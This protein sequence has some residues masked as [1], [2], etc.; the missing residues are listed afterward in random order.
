MITNLSEHQIDNS[1]TLII[2][3]VDPIG[4]KAVQ[5]WDLTVYPNPVHQT[6]YLESVLNLEKV[7]LIGIEG[8]VIQEVQ[9]NKLQ[10]SLDVSTLPQGIY[11]LEIYSPKGKVVKRIVKLK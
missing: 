11:F 8:R 7:R 5:G 2:T 4:S 1:T 9:P 6:I 3:S 10:T